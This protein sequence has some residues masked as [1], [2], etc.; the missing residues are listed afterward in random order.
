MNMAQRKV[1]IFAQASYALVNIV[2]F[3]QTSLKINPSSY[4]LN[5]FNLNIVVISEIVEYL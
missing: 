3:Y 4:K 1:E 2:T 5:T